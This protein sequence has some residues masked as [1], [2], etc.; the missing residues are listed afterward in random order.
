[1]SSARR[2]FSFLPENLT[3]GTNGLQVGTEK[4]SCPTDFTCCGYG[5]IR[6][7]SLCLLYQILMEKSIRNHIF[8][9]G[10]KIKKK[11]TASCKSQGTNYLSRLQGNYL[12]LRI[13]YHSLPIMSREKAKIFLLRKR[14]RC[15]NGRGGGYRY[16][17]TKF[18]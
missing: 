8:V 16:Q 11:Q 10:T 3:V 7:S 18:A 9:I 13:L 4:R 2:D 17:N 5:Q 15:G 6:N 12:L 1:M 14:R